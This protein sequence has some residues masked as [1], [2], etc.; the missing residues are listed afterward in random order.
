MI[1]N[2]E[3]VKVGDTIYHIQIVGSTI[4][5]KDSIKEHKVKYINRPP[6][7]L[8]VFISLDNTRFITPTKMFDFYTV[9]DKPS[10][11]I[12]RDDESITAVTEDVYATS[13]EECLR[14]AANTIKIRM[15]KIHKMITQCNSELEL[16][17]DTVMQLEDMKRCI[18]VEVVSET[19]IV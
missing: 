1:K 9:G 10:S 6:Q 19:V 16:L 17:G 14:I 18:P 4:Q 5:E 12:K 11:N 2:F 7:G 15:G 13:K 8:S 3:D